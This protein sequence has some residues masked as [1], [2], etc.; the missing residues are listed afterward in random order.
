VVQVVDPK[1]AMRIAG[2]DSLDRTSRLLA[3]FIPLR[4]EDLE[5]FQAA[6][7]RFLLYSGG[8][9]DWMTQYL[10]ERRY[11]LRLI[12]AKEAGRSLYIAER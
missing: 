1:T 10:V 4:V 12:S 2:A 11:R 7:Q 5:P 3:Q 8:N 6:H 9:Y